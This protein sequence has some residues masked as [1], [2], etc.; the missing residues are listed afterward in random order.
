MLLPLNLLL[1]AP[2]ALRSLHGLQSP[3]PSLCDAPP[4]EPSRATASLWGDQGLDGTKEAQLI[5]SHVFF[6]MLF[7]SDRFEPF[8]G[9]L[10]LSTMAEVR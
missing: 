8:L 10:A 7:G 6:T 2:S 9:Q 5:D 4:H 1:P 3:C